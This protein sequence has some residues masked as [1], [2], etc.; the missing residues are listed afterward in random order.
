MLRNKVK[1]VNQLFTASRLE[2]KR[3]TLLLYY[4]PNYRALLKFDLSLLPPFLKVSGR[5]TKQKY[6]VIIH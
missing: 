4:K 6:V 3:L 2:Q 5:F 1:L